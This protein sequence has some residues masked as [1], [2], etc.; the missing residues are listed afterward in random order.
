MLP[1]GHSSRCSDL[2]SNVAGRWGLGRLLMRRKGHSGLISSQQ[3][4]A[5]FGWHRDLASVVC[6][7]VLVVDL[8]LVLGGR[9]DESSLLMRGGR[10]SMSRGAGPLQLLC[11]GISSHAPPRDLGAKPRARVWDSE[12]SSGAGA[13]GQLCGAGYCIW[14]FE[15]RHCSHPIAYVPQET[16]HPVTAFPL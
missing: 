16:Q 9:S 6:Y 7:H 15:A 12:L 8:S 14:E 1:P 13:C 10:K 2:P 4:F 11:L 5:A 3:S